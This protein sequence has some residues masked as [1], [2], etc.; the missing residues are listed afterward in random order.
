MRIVKQLA[1]L[2]N[3]PTER[4]GNEYINIQQHIMRGVDGFNRHVTKNVHGIDTIPVVL[5]PVLVSNKG[6]KV[7]F[8]DSFANV[9]RE[10]DA[11]LT[12]EGIQGT[13]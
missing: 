10:D 6:G 9:E 4:S 5:L 12:S 1:I 11:M 7:R 3:I 2:F 13:V 8:Q